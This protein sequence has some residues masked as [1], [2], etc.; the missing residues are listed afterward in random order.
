MHQKGFRLILSSLRWHPVQSLI[1]LNARNLSKASTI[2]KKDKFIRE[3]M[4]LPFA[5]NLL[6]ITDL[7]NP[8][9]LSQ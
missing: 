4:F 2:E 1:I 3:F 9:I 5:K 6:L 8:E 7:C